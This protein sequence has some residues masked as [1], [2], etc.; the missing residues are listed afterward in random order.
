MFL[1][2][3]GMGQNLTTRICPIFDPQPFEGEQVP[4]L[5]PPTIF[6]HAI[7]SSRQQAPA[8]RSFFF[9]RSGARALLGASPFAAGVPGTQPVVLDMCHGRKRRREEAPLRSKRKRVKWVSLFR[10]APCSPPTKGE[11][12]AFGRP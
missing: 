2:H 9:L 11:T 4:I 12:T 6:S 5:D 3:M 10:I 8:W 1:W 7:F